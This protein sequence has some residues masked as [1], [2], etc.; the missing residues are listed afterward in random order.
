MSKKGKG[1]KKGGKKKTDDKFKDIDGTG[2]ES[3][4]LDDMME[5]M[6][7]IEEEWDNLAFEEISDDDLVW[8]NFE[9]GDEPVPSIEVET[10]MIVAKTSEVESPARKVIESLKARANYLKPEVSSGLR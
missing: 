4:E 5:D 6:D 7:D 2:G 3:D 8:D 1:P 9:E 10:G